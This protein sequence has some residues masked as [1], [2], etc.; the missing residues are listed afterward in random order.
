[1][2]ATAN[3][4]RYLEKDEIKTNSSKKKGKSRRRK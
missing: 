2:E 1:M 4:Y 3:T